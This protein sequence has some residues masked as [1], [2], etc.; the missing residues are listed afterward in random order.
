MNTSEPSPAFQVYPRDELS[1]LFGT[2]VAARGVYST[3]RAQCWLLTV[4][5]RAPR[6][7]ADLAGVS[8]ETFRKEWPKISKHFVRRG[9]GLVLPKL[10]EQHKRHVAHRAER[11][12]SGR[13]GMASRWKGHAPKKPRDAYKVILRVAHEL[14]L[15]KTTLDHIARVPKDQMEGEVLELL[16]KR[17]ARYKLDYA[18]P[19]D[20]ARRALSAAIWQQGKN[21]RT[22]IQRRKQG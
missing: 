6:A 10:I 1:D 22:R 9:A 15:E 3:L 13:A 16:K 12:A 17:C 5:P 18:N 14:L 19:P 21:F 2:S 7:L 8:L 11:S 4:L 20:V